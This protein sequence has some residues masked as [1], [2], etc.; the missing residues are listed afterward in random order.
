MTAATLRSSSV[1]L[2]GS[3]SRITSL[4]ENAGSLLRAG[5]HLCRPGRVMPGRI[6][7]GPGRKTFPR[8]S[9]LASA[10]DGAVADVTTMHVD[11]SA[12]AKPDPL[13]VAGTGGRGGVP[14]GLTRTSLGRGRGRANAAGGGAQ[15]RSGRWRQTLQSEGLRHRP[16]ARRSRV[17]HA[18]PQDGC[19]QPRRRPPD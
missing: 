1:H 4:L 10:T 14:K 12:G 5:E 19:A 11:G 3:R 7:I 9:P 17:L 13:V 8:Q 18:L 6:S 15:Q 2:R 16:L